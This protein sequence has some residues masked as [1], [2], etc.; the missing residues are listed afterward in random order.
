MKA[1]VSYSAVKGDNF[2]AVL[3]EVELEKPTAKGRDVLIA[4]KAVATNPVDTKVLGGVIGTAP[5]ENNPVTVGWDGSGVIDSIGEEVEHFKVGDEVY[6]AGSLIRSGSFAEFVLVDERIVALKPKN[7]NWAEAASLPLTTITAWETFIRQLHIS[8]PK[9]DEEREANAKKVLLIVGGAGGVG[10]IAT[11]IA[12]RILN[13]TVISTASREDTIDWAKKQ[14]ADFT[15]NHYNPLLPQIQQLGITGVNYFICNTDLTP[16]YYKEFI[17]CAAPFA[18]IGYITAKNS[19]DYNINLAALMMKSITLACELMFTRPIFGDD[20]EYQHELLT[21]AAEYVEK[22]V[23]THTKNYEYP[24][25]VENAAK[26]LSL[27]YS[28]KAIGKI[29]L[30][31]E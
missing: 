7:L 28:G 15:V 31:R 10:S 30:S 11:Q 16:H 22:K 5:S 3:K 23:L 9:T 8:I 12:K 24:F 1:I 14:G 13:L 17:E 29:V 26:A 20:I 2:E 25:T 27:Q 4:V 19:E 21:Q 6:F 18:V